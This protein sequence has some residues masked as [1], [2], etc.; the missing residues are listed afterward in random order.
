MMSPAWAAFE[1][2]SLRELLI[3]FDTVTVRIAW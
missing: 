1:P 2:D 3:F